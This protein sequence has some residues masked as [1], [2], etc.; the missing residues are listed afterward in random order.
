MYSVSSVNTIS[1]F[2]TSS[3]FSSE[4]DGSG[5][6]YGFHRDRFSFSSTSTD[7]N[8]EMTLD[9]RELGLP[10]RTGAGTPTQTTPRAEKAQYFDFD[11]GPPIPASGSAAA[12]ASQSGGTDT[13]PN[14]YGFIDEAERSGQATPKRS[15]FARSQPI[16]ALAAPPPPAPTFARQ[17]SASPSRPLA[18][19][20]RDVFFAPTRN[21]SRADSAAKEGEVPAS[22][23]QRQ[24]TGGADWESLHGEQGSEWGEDE[25]GYEWLDKGGLPIAQNGK[26]GEGEDQGTGR[27][28]RSIL[29]S[30]SK[31]FAKLKMVVSASIG[32]DSH[33]VGD[34][35]NGSKEGREGRKL[36]KH[37]ILPRR[38]APPPPAAPG[39]KVPPKPV[40]EGEMNHL[41][42]QGIQRAA[43]PNALASAAASGSTETLVGMK[44][45]SGLADTAGAH[46]LHAPSAQSAT[47]APT[48][49]PLR[50]TPGSPTRPNPPFQ[51]GSHLSIQS[52]SFSLY[53]LDG[54][55]SPSARTP[56]ATT[57]SGGEMAF[58]K[59]TYT[60]VSAS[61][62]AAA[63]VKPRTQ[64][65][66]L[67]PA[68]PRSP[69]LDV[70]EA[71]KGDL[72]ERGVWA[73][74][75]GDLP[76]AAWYFRQAADAGS[77]TGRIYWGE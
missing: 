48:M 6:G 47:L 77:V 70:R 72:L 53:D 5:P 14:S 55:S 66:P 28:H 71:S 65:D 62:L 76:K 63:E 20:H 34:S 18:E 54:S 3:A 74:E 24:S 23:P 73:R 41:I 22:L 35:S 33:G 27:E 4:D 68:A 19:T 50:D 52:N 12:L 16:G 36:K 29:S 69:L 57:P 8:D 60:K 59:G 2:D 46:V 9:I 31:G 11:L 21:R 67:T 58:P 64:S 7:G 44:S 37:V 40:L 30:P 61:T 17:P 43:S 49:V 51:R 32:A 13:G 56:R 15:A 25:A 10:R 75:K 39:L 26:E 45:K 1:S 38:A 42:Q